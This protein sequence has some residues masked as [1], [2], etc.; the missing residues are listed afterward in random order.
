M[1][2]LPP[3]YLDSRTPSDVIVTDHAVPALLAADLGEPLGEPVRDLPVVPAEP[4]HELVTVGDSLTHGMSSAAVF[5]TD[6]SWPM[7]VSEGLGGRRLDVPGAAHR[8]GRSRSGVIE[9]RWEDE[10]D[11]PGPRGVH[12]QV[13]GLPALERRERPV[14]ADEPQQ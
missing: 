2:D 11:D 4:A 8:V 7:L 6:L 10:D 1:P 5:H 3:E 14:P 13:A 12:R 9:Q